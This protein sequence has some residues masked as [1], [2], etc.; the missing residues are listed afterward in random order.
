MDA[1]VRGAAARGSSGTTGR[2]RRR[3]NAGRV[4]AEADI[5]GTADA[6]CAKWHVTANEA[7]PF[8]TGER[9]DTHQDT[10]PGAF[11]V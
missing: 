8:A 9:P 6:K 11:R 5:D 3:R 10:P 4:A 2:G 1:F 7:D